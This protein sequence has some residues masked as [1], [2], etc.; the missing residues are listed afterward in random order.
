[1]QLP[2]TVQVGPFRYDV[3]VVDDFIVQHNLMGQQLQHKLVLR[4]ATGMAQ[5]QLTQTLLH[6]LIH[7]ASEAYNINLEEEQVNQLA[8]VLL[9]TIQRNGLDFR[10]DYSYD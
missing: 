4:V 6:E 8:T 3:L 10:R 1:M 7:A 9:D 2:E 5:T